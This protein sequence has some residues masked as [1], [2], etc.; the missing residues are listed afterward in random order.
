[1]EMN[2]QT[3]APIR[4]TRAGEDDDVLELVAQGWVL[5]SYV[6][7]RPAEV[8]G[9]R[10]LAVDWSTITVELVWTDGSVDFIAEHG[11]VDRADITA[12]AFGSIWTDRVG[13]VVPTFFA[14]SAR[15]MVELVEFFQDGEP[16]DQQARYLGRYLNAF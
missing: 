13:R 3:V 14:E 6:R 8:P 4:I 15:L 7:A 2:T 16:T 12:A 9:D 5:P 11:S 10:A 1:M